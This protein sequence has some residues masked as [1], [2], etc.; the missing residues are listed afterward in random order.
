MSR[1]LPGIPAN[2]IRVAVIRGSSSAC[3]LFGP[4]WGPVEFCRGK[5]DENEN[6]SALVRGRG[7]G[8][9]PPEEANGPAIPRGVARAGRRRLVL[10]DSGGHIGSGQ[11]AG[12]CEGRAA[13]PARSGPS[14]GSC[15][16]AAE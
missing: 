15:N 3:W 9:G 11:E 14:S 5:G 12:G 7:R 1:E 8:S 4:D 10:A 13:G 2:G 6:G 16:A